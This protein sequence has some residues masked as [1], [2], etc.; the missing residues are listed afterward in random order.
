MSVARWEGESYREESHMYVS[1]AKINQRCH[2]EH[3]AD[4]VA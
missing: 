1:V 3:H 2:R 4:S